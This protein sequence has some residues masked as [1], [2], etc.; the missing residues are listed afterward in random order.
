MSGDMHVDGKLI[1]ETSIEA[2]N[3]IRAKGLLKEQQ[4]AVYAILF[5]YGPLTSRELDGYLAKPGVD[6]DRPSYHKRLSE[7]ERLG[8]VRPMGKR[9]CSISGRTVMAWDVTAKLPQEPPKTVRRP[10]KKDLRQAGEELLDLM[11]ELAAEYSEVGKE[12]PKA[13][14][15][16][17]KW[18][19]MQ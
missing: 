12:I 17:A 15:K 1:R 9:K 14:F 7:L 10:S 5:Q 18:M 8:C 13:L 2:Y 16:V 6:G 3:E 4:L 11:P 19:V